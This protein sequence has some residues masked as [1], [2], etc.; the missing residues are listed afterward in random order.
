MGAALIALLLRCD[1]GA[2]LIPT[3]P[4]RTL[5]RRAS[6]QEGFYLADMPSELGG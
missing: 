3:S 4:G 1:P 6:A 5:F 2:E